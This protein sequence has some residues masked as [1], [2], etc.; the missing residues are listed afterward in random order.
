MLLEFKTAR[1]AYGQRKYL[2]IDTNNRTF[3]TFCRSMVVPGV[4]VKTNDY[5]QILSTVKSAGFK[6]IEE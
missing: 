2:Q 3:T 4:E 6:C 1:A 5:K